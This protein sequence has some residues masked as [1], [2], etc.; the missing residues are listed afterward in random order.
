MMKRIERWLLVGALLPCLIAGA[1]SAGYA[2][3]SSAT[4]PRAPLETFVRQVARLWA[5]SEA[6]EL[7]EL[8]P[9]DGRILLELGRE[10]AEPVQQR[11]AQAALRAFFSEREH[12]SI[13]PLRVTVAGGEPM[14]GFGEL[15]WTSRAHGVATPEIFTLYIGAVWEGDSWRVRELRLLR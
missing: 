4:V 8:A 13:R 11:H 6:G 3:N 5:M 15:A 9:A 2:Q 1:L 7:T 14:Q 10:G 12:V